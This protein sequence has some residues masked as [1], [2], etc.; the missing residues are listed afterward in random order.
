[1][2]KSGTNAQIEHMEGNILTIQ[3]KYFIEQN[4]LSNF[5]RSKIFDKIQQIYCAQ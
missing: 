2:H 4:V 3:E 5:I 1:M